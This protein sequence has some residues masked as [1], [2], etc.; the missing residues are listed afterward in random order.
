MA[1]TPRPTLQELYPN[2]T[3]EWYA[4]MKRSLDGYLKLALQIWDDLR[5]DPKRY[6]VFKERLVKKKAEETTSERA[7]PGHAIP[8]TCRSESR[9]TI[10]SIQRK[11]PPR[12]QENVG[13]ADVF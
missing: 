10:D 4:E 1:E 9:R 6:R 7:V 3:P 12:K 2:H 11:W 8:T 5:A 13:V